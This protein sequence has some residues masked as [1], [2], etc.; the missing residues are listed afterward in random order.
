MKIDS[1]PGEGP[2]YVE[3]VEYMEYVEYIFVQY[4]TGPAAADAR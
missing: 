3:Y 4:D 1:C 2:G